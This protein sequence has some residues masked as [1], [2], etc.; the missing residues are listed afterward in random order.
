MVFKSSSKEGSQTW[1]PSSKSP[2]QI[3]FQGDTNTIQLLVNHGAMCPNTEVTEH[4]EWGWVGS[5][6]PRVVEMWEDFLSGYYDCLDS[7]SPCGPACLAL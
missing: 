1:I 4:G 5:L 2:A 6:V 7:V 3:A